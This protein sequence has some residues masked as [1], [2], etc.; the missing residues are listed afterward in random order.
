MRVTDEVL[1]S[2]PKSHPESY[3]EMMTK[4][5]E[6]PNSLPLRILSWVFH[7][8]E[9]LR[10]EELLEALEITEND[11]DLKEKR[12]YDERK[13]LEV[14]EN[15]IEYDDQTTKFVRFAHDTVQEY[16][17]S[18]NKH[19]LHPRNEL[20][21]TCLWYI[22][23]KTFRDP[24]QKEEYLRKRLQRYKFSSYVAQFWGL[25]MRG[26][27]ENDLEDLIFQTFRAAGY[28]KSMIQIRTYVDVNFGGKFVDP[29]ETY[30]FHAV[31]ADGLTR[32]CE[33]LLGSTT[34]DDD[35]KYRQPYRANGSILGHINAA[36]DRGWTPLH[37]AAANG[38][39]EIVRM[40]L[41][42][43]TIDVNVQNDHHATPLHLAAKNGCLEIVTSLVGS[44]NDITK[45]DRNGSTA[46]HWAARAGH[47]HVVKYLSTAAPEKDPLMQT[48]ALGATVLHEAAT[49]GRIE[50][51]KWL[52]DERKNLLPMTNKYRETALHCAALQGHLEIVTY[53]V[54]KG[55]D[56][57]ATDSRGQ[58]AR[59]VAD[60]RKYGE[61]EQHLSKAEWRARGPLVRI[62]S[63][64][65]SVAVPLG[66][67][68]AN[69]IAE[70]VLSFIYQGG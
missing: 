21:M 27:P 37:F 8:P 13:I 68:P 31:A 30:L 48:G 22:K 66:N 50:V 3:Q 33:R 11:E 49:L 61:I 18:N 16:I 1:E 57:S 15:L 42:Q 7:S 23:L 19:H 45:P 24:C 70:S 56:I 58:T 59:Q 17:D 26:D 46:I 4:V 32:L 6:Y 52:V 47:K 36:D 60:T 43:D 55:I 20:A 63:P 2:L 41:R 28:L 65:F 51:V 5:I 9:H 35:D 40:L 29:R 34:T 38:H 69:N 53:L 39:S 25:F 14:C 62:V 64:T 54:D 44:M 12:I 67:D 10:M